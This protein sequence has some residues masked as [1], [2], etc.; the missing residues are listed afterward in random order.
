MADTNAFATDVLPNIQGISL[1]RLSKASGL[2][3]SY[4]SKIR[5]GLV[6][7]HPMHWDA[8]GLVRE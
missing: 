5:Q 8:F 7:P 1:T 6:V 4:C 2:S 3:L